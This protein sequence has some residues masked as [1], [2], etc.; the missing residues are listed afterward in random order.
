MVNFGRKKKWFFGDRKHID[1]KKAE[2][3]KANL[4][5][6]RQLMDTGDLSGYVALIR[7]L[8]PGITDAEMEVKV[9]LFF[10]HRAMH[11]SDDHYLS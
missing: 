8:K 5:A 11:P 10:E 2:Q 3:R 9:R 1:E 6:L 4:S 7:E